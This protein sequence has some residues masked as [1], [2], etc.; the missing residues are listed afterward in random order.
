MSVIRLKRANVSRLQPLIWQRRAS[1]LVACG[2]GDKR[3]FRND[4]CWRKLH[5]RFAERK[6]IYHRLYRRASWARRFRKPAPV[7]APVRQQSFSDVVDLARD[8]PILSVSTKTMQF[9]FVYS[10]YQAVVDTLAC[11][12]HPHWFAGSTRQFPNFRTAQSSIECHWIMIFQL[13][14]SLK[15]DE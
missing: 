12:P 1:V 7:T 2:N 3:V 14:K 10:A 13:L 9:A 4:G 8:L 15:T 11:G 6:P 5:I